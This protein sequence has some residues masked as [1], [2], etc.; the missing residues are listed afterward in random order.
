MTGDLD[1]DALGT[2]A[3]LYLLFGRITRALRRSGDAGALSPG[4]GSALA[5]LVRSGPMRLSDLAATE[6]VSAPTMSRIVA[7]LDASGHLRREADRS[8]GRAT[9]LS[10]TE[11][12]KA[13]VSGLTSDRIQ[14]FAAALAQLE[15]TTRETL[16]AALV[17]LEDALA[18]DDGGLG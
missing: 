7:A 15:P 3:D 4:S 18:D 8:D 2:A 6:R 9:L 1:D 10:A 13:L 5:T 11:T 14:R 12:G 16:A 17:Q